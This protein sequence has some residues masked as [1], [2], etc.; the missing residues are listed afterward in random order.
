MAEIETV[1]RKGSMSRRRF[2]QTSA[3]SAAAVSMITVPKLRAFER[4]EQRPPRIASTGS[5]VPSTC[6]G[7]T[8]WCP[9]EI[10]VQEGRA[11][12]VR[13]NPLSHSNKGHV[14]PK[15]HMLIQQVYDPD[16]IKV[17]MKRTN[18]AKGKGINPGFVPI[19]WDEAIDTIATKMMELRDADETHKFLM[20]RGRY[21]NA[22]TRIIY[23]SFPKLFGSPNGISHSAACAEAEKFG[24]Y[25]TEAR[26]DYRQYDLPATDCLVCWGMDPLSSNR[27][28]PF[29]LAAIPEI[30]ERGAKIISI[31]PRLNATSLK[32]HI[33][34]PVTPGQDG[35]LAS[36]IAHVILTEGRW[37]KEFVGDFNDNVNRF[38]TDQVVDEATFNEIH[39]HG[40]VKWWNLELKDKTPAWAS[41][42][43]GLPS[44]QIIAAARMM[45]DAAPR[46]CIWLGPGA[47]MSPRGSYSAM[48]IHALNG[49]LGSADSEGGIFYKPGSTRPALPSIANYQDD[50]A[51]AGVKNAKIDQRGTLRLPA[52]NAGRSGA[53]VVSNRVAQA[54]LDEDPYDIKVVIGDWVN[55]NF[56]GYQTELWDRAMAKVPFF[57]LCGTHASEMSMFADIVLPAPHHAAERYS[58]SDNAGNRYSFI[59]IQQPVIEPLWD[60]RN[61]EAE[62]P[63]LIAEKLRDKGFSDMYDYYSTEIKDPDTDATPTN[64]AEFNLYVTKIYL[65]DA[66]TK[67]GGWEEFKKTGITSYGP[68]QFGQRWSNMGTE[69]KKFEFFSETLKKAL[70]GHA[71]KHSTTIDDV[72]AQCNLVAQG[73]LAFVPHY[74]PPLRIGSKAAYPL[75]FVDCKSRL[76]REGRSANETWYQEF[77]KVD[78]GDKSWDDVVKLNPRDAASLNLNEGDLV[79]IHSEVGSIKAKVHIWPGIA[80]GV[81]TKAF[82]QG[83]WAYGKIAAKDF[84]A[85][86]ARGGNNNDILPEAYDRLSGSSARN[87]GFFG[88]RIDP[89]TRVKDAP[90][91]GDFDLSPI[92][93]NPVNGP[94][95]MATVYAAQSAQVRLELYNTL[96]AKVLDIAD[97]R[98]EAGTHTLPVDV[99][100]LPAGM[101]LLRMQSGKFSKSQK[102]VIQR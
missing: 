10:F 28:L 92:Y 3:I 18:P 94:R 77:K 33:W 69:T 88:V 71:D 23:D 50:K 21:S 76:N 53:G 16:R 41:T 57:V 39:S 37:S 34:M 29:A 58:G 86:E 22:Q 44:T 49:L 20:L 52:L 25:Y 83:H 65:K 70:Q 26:W 97:M 51:K 11:T 84:A 100:A 102:L 59:S 46:T 91:A 35:A 60:V 19:T 80:Q 64:A 99:H 81:I 54:I 17:P 31:D 90:L 42:M 48:A 8:Q 79:S 24:A 68:A 14:C 7:C 89:V 67:A 73:D 95:A 78:P 13:G 93:P 4:L 85:F 82:G 75:E 63:W 45:A 61:S 43:T 101:Y 38:I 32:S 55:Y 74:E 2:M 62:V 96:G 47:C 6:Q 9:I 36:A 15:G 87:G 66:Y 5:W 27:H 1:T 56:S 40:L 98:L 12:K 30:L 72:L